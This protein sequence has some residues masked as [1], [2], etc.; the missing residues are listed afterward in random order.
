MVQT[1]E[2]VK[3]ERQQL[4]FDLICGVICSVTALS[5]IIY[6]T[7]VFGISDMSGWLVGFSFW[8]VYLI[9]SLFLISIGLYSRWKDKH[10]DDQTPRKDL[11]AP[12][13]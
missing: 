13:V 5:G 11:K 9:F 3:K 10:F 12:I 6:M 8:M 7:V 4:Y 2:K 1:E